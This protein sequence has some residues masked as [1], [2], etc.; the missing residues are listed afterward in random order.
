M[1]VGGSPTPTPAAAAAAT[2]P[3]TTTTTNPAMSVLL[4]AGDNA[5]RSFET[6]PHKFWAWVSI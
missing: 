4:V 5:E 1:K 6:Q 2:A 3:T